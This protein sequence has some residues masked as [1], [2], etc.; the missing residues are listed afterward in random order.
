MD[1]S[2]LLL[3]LAA[4]LVGVAL[5][6]L[7][8]R[9]SAATR[10][11]RAEAERDA[12]VKRAADVTADREQLAHQFRSLS[13]D[14]LEKQTKQADRAAELRLTPISEALR[15]LQQRLAEVE[16]QR[17]A[18]AAELRQQVEGVR[19]SGEAVRKEAASLATALRAPH[20][21]GAWGES[22]LRRIAE[23]AGLVEHCHF[24]T[25]TSYTSSE[26]NRLRPDMRIDLDGG[27]AVFVD[28]K[29]PLSAVLE[30]CQAED[31]EERAAHLRRFVRHVRT[32]IDQL[33]AKEY[34]ALDAG[35]PEFVVLFLGSDEFY[36][37]ALEQQPTLH[38]Y[39]AARRITL[40]GPGL[41]IPLL[42]IIS[43][44]WRQSRLAESATRISALGRELYSRLATLG[45]HF[46]KLGASI[47]GTVKNYN[48]AMGTLESRVLVS[49]RRFRALDVSMDE[50]PR[51]SS[52]DEGVRTPVAPELAAPPE[53]G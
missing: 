9:Q 18:L 30:A 27:R 49:A 3:A 25:Q 33:S 12:A 35:S 38:E 41:L 24:E 29:V 10:T 31:E 23:V 47:N 17:T 19:V 46:E 2:S 50:L 15:Q 16:N 45:S 51:L 21:R 22:S 53:A 11:A 48:A 5:G 42:Q 36:R 32:H 20:V 43:H 26:G 34:W 14:A 8:A 28:S 6:F 44:G 52:V 13:A 1:T 4:L 37:L 39:A 7:L 40:A